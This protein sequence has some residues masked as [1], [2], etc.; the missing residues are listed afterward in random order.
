[1]AKKNLLNTIIILAAIILVIIISLKLFAVEESTLT[2]SGPNIYRAVYVYETM[3]EQGYSVDLSLI[4]KWTDT[5][6]KF[7]GSG[8]IIDTKP[9]FAGLL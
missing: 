3:N 4:G 5:G 6:E 8:L 7:E 1:M 2:F 9:A